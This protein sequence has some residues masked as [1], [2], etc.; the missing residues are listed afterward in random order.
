MSLQGLRKETVSTFGGPVLQPDVEIEDVPSEALLEARN[1]AYGKG[2]VMTREGHASLFNPASAIKAMKNWVA[3]GLN[4]LVYIRGD[5][6]VIVRNLA[7]NT[8]QDI[9]TFTAANPVFQLAGD[10][11]YF[12]GE[13]DARVWDGLFI[14]AVPSVF[15][16]FSPPLNI[17][18]SI[19]E[20]ATNADVTAGTHR[21]GYI[22]TST[23]GFVGKP[24]PAPPGGDFTP[25][26]FVATGG[27][28]LT[29]Q[30]SF[31]T[32]PIWAKYIT[33]I[34]TDK[35]N[36]E[37]FFFV[38]G[39]QFALPS[40]QGPHT[41]Y[42]PFKVGDEQLRLAGK[43]AF[44]YRYLLTQDGAGNLPIQVKAITEYGNRMVWL[45]GNR[46]YISDPSNYE[47]ITNDQH[48]KMLPGDKDITAAFVIRGVLYLAGPHY[49]YSLADN[50]DKPVTWGLPSEVSSGIGIPSQNAVTDG[51]D[52]GYVVLASE[53]GLYMF[54]GGRFDEF[55][56]NRWQMNDW[57]RINWAYAHKIRVV[58]YREDKRIYVAVPLDSATECSHIMT[59]YYHDG[60]DYRTVKYSLDDIASYQISCIEI[61]KTQASGR[62]DLLVA[63]A[64]ANHVLR[65]R[66]LKETFSSPSSRDDNTAAITSVIES[67]KMPSGVGG[68]SLQHRGVQY[69]I[70]GSGTIAPQVRTVSNEQTAYLAPIRLQASPSSEALRRFYL[71]GAAA[72]H[73]IS[74]SSSSGWWMLSSI[75]HYFKPWVYGKAE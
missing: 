41:V 10:K 29:V 17:T 23:S 12:A 36:H 49:V 46:A 27:K 71:A 11:L 60:L 21:F 31:T 19:S 72:S 7:D 69:R 62:R 9:A 5:G 57:R 70:S 4:R 68:P 20:T 26:T 52:Y 39:T 37:A 16:P 66:S 13:G 25:A 22:L 24:G 67:A 14:N 28:E 43:E 44:D 45:A 34:A 50:D 3:L 18:P 42:L 63:P 1:V 51:S 6:H 54:D 75:T 48:V 65:R 33:L 2:F 58:D 8:E 40:G 55:P 53:S 74:M 47:A 32:V 61:A 15:K 59:F 73:R 35:D 64:T 38:P 56:L 30:V